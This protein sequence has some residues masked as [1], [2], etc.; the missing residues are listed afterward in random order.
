MKMFSNC[1]SLEKL[2]GEL[3]RY[4]VTYQDICPSGFT[5]FKPLPAIFAG[6]ESLDIGTGAIKKDAEAYIYISIDE[7]IVYD[8][9]EGRINISVDGV[10]CDYMGETSSVGYDYSG[11][12]LYKYKVN[13]DLSE[14]NSHTLEF[15]GEDE[16]SI[17]ALTY[18]ELAVS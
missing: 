9:E 15:S 5:P 2:E 16:H 17:V 13:T 6:K 14:K 12:T 11:K 1:T 8:M 18:I 7:E 10:T 3:K 4:V